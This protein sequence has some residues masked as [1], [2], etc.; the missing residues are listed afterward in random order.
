VYNRYLA[1][2]ALLF[3]TTTVL[4]AVYRQHKLDLY[5]S[6]YLIEYLAATLVFVYLHP[7]ARRLLG[8]LGYF[9]FAGFMV[10]VA[11]KA[12]EILVRGGTPS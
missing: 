4:L 10:I 9:L 7:R 12:F 8:F 1:T 2:L 5:F 11:L 6:L 3:T